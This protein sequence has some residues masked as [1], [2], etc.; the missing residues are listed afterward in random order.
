MSDECKNTQSFNVTDTEIDK[1]IR[2]LGMYELQNKLLTELYGC[3]HLEVDE[4]MTG[5]REVVRM[6]FE[7]KPSL[8][9]DI[10]WFR[11]LVY[12]LNLSPDTFE[13]YIPED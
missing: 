1:I 11:Q 6:V 5:E 3:S 7:D 8:D 12:D 13:T 4:D 2:R 9:I 10:N